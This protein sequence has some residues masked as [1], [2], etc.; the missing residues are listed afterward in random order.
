M[1]NPVIMHINYFEVG[2]SI[3][4]ICKHARKLGFDGIEFRRSVK[5]MGQKEYVQEVAKWTKK[6]CIGYV[7]F[8]GPGIDVMTKDANV[9]R[10]EIASY[11]NFLDVASSEIKLTV[12]NFMTGWL[13]RADIQMT[14]Y[15]Q[16]G[17][18]CA[19]DWHWQTAAEACREIADYAKDFGVK[20]AF[21]THM[22]Y[23]HDR[24]GTAKK[25]CDMINRPN[26]GINLDYGNIVYMADKEETLD[27]AID[28]CGDKLFYTHLK[29]SASGASNLKRIP[30][31]LA[32]GDINHRAYLK[33]LDSL[34]FG[35]LIGIEA[36]RPGDGEWYAK[37]DLAYIR[38]LLENINEN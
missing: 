15:D 8:G 13:S 36:P 20:F 26:F 23:I 5:Y 32:S 19:E 7:L 9:I 22:G 17:S 27:K 25:L 6:Y 1:N 18:G 33:K 3:E 37:E 2:Q 29:N 11:K 16:I 21:E 10:S 4:Y 30:T 38:A 31:A 14:E 28:I 35:G 12:I 24:A 34:N